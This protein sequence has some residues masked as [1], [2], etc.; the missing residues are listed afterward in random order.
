M[1]VSRPGIKSKPQLQPTLELWQFR[2]LNPLCHRRNSYQIILIIK[3][4]CIAL[5]LEKYFHDLLSWPAITLDYFASFYSKIP[6]KMC[7]L[8]LFAIP[9]LLFLTNPF[10]S[11]FCCHYFIPN[12][13]TSVIN[14]LLLASQLL[15]LFLLNLSV[16][17]DSINHSLFLKKN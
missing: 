5:I 11:C 7:L 1:E 2:I 3:Y 16:I 17:V 13:A 10:Q 14:D 6:W 15:V 12:I 9:R 4:V 8:F